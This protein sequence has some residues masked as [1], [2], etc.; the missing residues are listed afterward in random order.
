MS[1]PGQQAATTPVPLVMGVVNLTPDS[2]SDG[3]DHPT[4]ATAVAHALELLNHGADWLDL[5]GESTRPGADPVPEDE[6]IRRVVPVV[7]ALL[8]TRPD[9]VVSV[10]TRRVEVAR[11]A[12]DAGARIVNDVTGLED[13]QMRQLCAA[14]GVTCVVMHKR[15]SPATMQQ[16]TTYRDLVGDVRD[17]LVTQTELARAAGVRQDRLIVDPGIGFGKALA[18]NPRLIR[19]TPIFAKIGYPVLV[20]ASRKRFVGALTGRSDPKARRDGSVGAALAAAVGGARVLRVHDV[21]ATRDALSV[22]V[23]CA[24]LDALGTLA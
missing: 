6:E 13:P 20:G 14:T 21:R 12:I 23:P 22:F 18:D 19:A 1:E 10:D 5:G 17:Y 24:G 8:A 4:V 9:A 15:G 7:R 3:G 11:Q 16:D 2:F